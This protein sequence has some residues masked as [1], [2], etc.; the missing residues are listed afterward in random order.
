MTFAKSVRGA[1][2]S[3]PNGEPNP[4]GVSHQERGRIT[5]FHSETCLAART[6]RGR[7]PHCPSVTSG[8]A[9]LTVKSTGGGGTWTRTQWLF[10]YLTL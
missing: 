4:V 3:G 1:A 6:L 8:P 7:G 10:F 5:G 2:G 9:L